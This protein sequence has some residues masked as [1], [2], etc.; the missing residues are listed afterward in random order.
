[1]PQALSS[2]RRQRGYWK[3]I[4]SSHSAAHQGKCPLCVQ[5]S[6]PCMQTQKQE[7]VEHAREWPGNLSHGFPACNTCKMHFYTVSQADTL[8]LYYIT[9]GRTMSSVS[10]VDMS[11]RME[12]C[13]SSARSA[14]SCSAC[15]PMILAFSASP[16]SVRARRS[17]STGLYS[18]ALKPFC[19]RA[20]IF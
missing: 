15:A 7:H 12:T 14:A 17:A 10:A 5:Y 3:G 16:C 1:M 20:W 9:A 6:V 4:V 11:V 2:R 13:S 18:G 8:R 19:A